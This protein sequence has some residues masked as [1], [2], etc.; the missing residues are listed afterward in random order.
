MIPL[1]V[2]IAAHDAGMCVIP[3]TQDGKKRPMVPW[4]RYESERPTPSRL[5]RWYGAGLTGIGVVCGPISGNLVMLEAETDEMAQ[6]LRRVASL[7]GLGDVMARLD[8]GYLERTPGGGVHWLLRC[9]ELGGNT[10]LASRIKTPGERKHEHDNRQVLIE[11]REAGGYTVIAPSHGTVHP[12]GRP[13]MLLAGGF[14]T[15]PTVTP[16][17]RSALWRA[18]RD[19]DELPVVEAPVRRPSTERDGESVADQFNRRVTW[20][21]LLEPVS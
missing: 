1:D 18:A 9:S 12:T 3:P 17:E 15:V 7:F 20:R 16:D 11:T 2:A 4:R 6:Q 21:E 8:A 5:A 13:Y 19:L 14:D 10:K